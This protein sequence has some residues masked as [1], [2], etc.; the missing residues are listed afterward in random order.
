MGS[1]KPAFSKYKVIVSNYNGERWSSETETAFDNYVKKGGGFV[2]VH[3]AD[4]A[5]PEWPAY[6]EM[7]GVGGWGD[8]TEKSGPYIRFRDGKMLL[9]PT[10]GRGGS[11][12]KQHEFVVEALQPKHPILRGLPTRWLHTQD[13]L[14]DRLRGPAKSVQVLA[15]SMSTRETNG[16]GEIEPM[17]MTISYGKGRVF[18]TVLGHS[19]V[20][21]QCV[22]FATTFQR[23][24]EW[25]ATGR[26]TQKVPANF[27]TSDKTS[28]R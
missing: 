22:G 1:F 19:V 4:N 6:N 8:R 18:H 23:G 9:D 25:V 12:G 3:A 21:I 13:E 15:T 10:P 11:H 2:S 14:Y 17:L 20:S 28:S 27:P 7:I 24:V 26:V 16:S 5:F